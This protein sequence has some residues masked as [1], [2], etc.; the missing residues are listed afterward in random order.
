MCLVPLFC[1]YSSH[2]RR[3]RFAAVGMLGLSGEQQ[4]REAQGDRA[5]RRD[6]T[7]DNCD[8]ARRGRTAEV[9]LARGAKCDAGPL[10]R[11]ATSAAFLRRVVSLSSATPLREIFGRAV[12]ER[13]SRVST[14]TTVTQS[15]AAEV[16]VSRAS[17]LDDLR[18]SEAS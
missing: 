9:G 15:R 4:Q 16:S 3:E 14:L 13:R 6:V 1:G 17:S 8:G 5:V 10:F 12:R 18:E 7:A 2:V 11:V